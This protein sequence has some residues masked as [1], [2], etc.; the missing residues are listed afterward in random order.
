M[1]Q[2]LEDPCRGQEN[3]AE[4]R[5]HTS[6]PLAT[7]M[8]T[9]S[10]EDLPGSSACI[11]RTS[12]LS[13]HHFWGGLDATMRLGRICRTFGR[14]LS[15]H[16]NSHL[17]ISMMAMAHLGVAVPEIS[18]EIDTHYPWQSDEVIQGGRIRFEDG[19]IDVPAKPGLGV[20]LDREALNRLHQ[21]YLDCG[22]RDRNDEAEMQKVNP[23]W[24]FKNHIF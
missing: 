4:L 13:D 24:T 1:L 9:T 22:I 21:N 10:F 14:G 12:S 6:I 3:M 19:C 11:R 20:E 8:C 5:K 18:Y 17:G 7:N 23:G 2:Y 15:M 16:S